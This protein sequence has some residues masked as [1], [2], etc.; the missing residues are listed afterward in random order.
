M[1]INASWKFRCKVTPFVR[2]QSDPPFRLKVTPWAYD[3]KP[4]QNAG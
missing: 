4:K 2:S 1:F 3:W